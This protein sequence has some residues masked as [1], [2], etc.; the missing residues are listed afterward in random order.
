MRLKTGLVALAIIA[1]TGA[2]WA[3]S[4]WTT[5]YQHR[6]WEVDFV[7]FD[8]GTA[9]CVAQVSEGGESF[10]L[11]AD[12]SEQVRMQFFSDA[13]NFDDSYVDIRV[14]IDRR[15]VWNLTNANLYKNSVLF[16]IEDSKQGVEFITE[17]M[18]GNVLYLG[19]DSGDTVQS[20]SLAG[21]SAAIGKLIDCVGA[22]QRGASRN[23]NPFK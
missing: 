2:A 14:Q 9:S 6:A 16:D 12:S 15:P 23:S 11:W 1:T 18:R 13:W 20:Y 22:L 19:N 8:D 7:S 21:S 10:S 4:Q 3:D 17:I 5:I